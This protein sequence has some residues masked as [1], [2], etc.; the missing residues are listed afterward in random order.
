MTVYRYVTPTRSGKWYPTVE[1]AQKAASKIGAGF[2]DEASGRFYRYPQAMLEAQP[3]TPTTSRSMHMA[4]SLLR[5]PAP[6]MSQ[7]G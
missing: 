2:W 1:A 3:G 6:C 4:Q 5:L 7:H